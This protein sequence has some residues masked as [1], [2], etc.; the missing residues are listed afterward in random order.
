ME[1]FIWVTFSILTISVIA[2][3][4]VDFY[5]TRKEKKNPATSVLRPNRFFYIVGIGGGIFLPAIPLLGFLDTVS[6]EYEVIIY[7][8]LSILLMGSL[9]GYLVFFYLNY[10]VI[11]YEDY[12][13]YQ[14][15]WRIKKKIYYKDIVIDNSKLYPQV[16][17]KRENGKTKLV[18]K[19]AGV[20]ENEICFTE[21]YKTWKNQPKKKKEETT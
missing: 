2:I 17:Q 9:G 5:A 14:N 7:M 11:V 8:I 10:K 21:A 12:F 3:I 15:F 18:F 19:L 1:I 6:S 13:I 20:L 16:R 4:C